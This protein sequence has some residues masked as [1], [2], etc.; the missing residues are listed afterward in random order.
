MKI[1]TF[2][3]QSRFQFVWWIPAREVRPPAEKKREAEKTAEKK[4]EAVKTAKPHPG[5]NDVCT[6]HL[7]SCT[8]F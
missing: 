1:L 6:S 4:I 3:G 2:P 8:L 7:Q 5:G